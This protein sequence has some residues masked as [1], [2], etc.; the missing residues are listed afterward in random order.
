MVRLLDGF[1]A[2]DADDQG[3]LGEAQTLVAGGYREILRLADE[4]TEPK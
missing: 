3:L 1:A 4:G 2:P